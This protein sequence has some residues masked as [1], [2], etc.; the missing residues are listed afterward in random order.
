MTLNTGL[1]YLVFFILA[2]I[3]LFAGVMTVSLRNVVHSALALIGTFF[4]VA[5]IYLMLEAEFLAVVQVLIYVGAVSVLILFSIMLTRGLMQSTQ[6]SFNNQWGLAALVAFALFAGMT[7]I[8][9]A[10]NWPVGSTPITTDLV[11]TLGKLLVTSYV[12]PFEVVSVLLLGALVGA[13]LIA[14]D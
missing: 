7:I 5:G 12:L 1:Y 8:A 9:I 13:L 3:T 11:P 4:G 14:R 10:G 2:A 6:T